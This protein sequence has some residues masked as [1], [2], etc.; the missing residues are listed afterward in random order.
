MT[1]RASTFGGDLG[2]AL[3]DLPL[4]PLP[5]VVL[6]PGA[7][8]PLHIFEP[9]YRAMIR[10]VLATH[11]ALAVVNV[12]DPSK[13]DERGMPVLATVAGVG[14]ILDHVE[15]PSGRFNILVRGR[16]RVALEERPFVPPYRRALATVLATTDE[17]VP[18]ESLAALMAASSAFVTLMRRR[19]ATF[20]LRAPKD[21][22]AGGFADHCAQQLLIDPRDRQAV[23]EATSVRER[24]RLVTETLSLQRMTLT[25]GHGAMN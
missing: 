3:S 15:L 14:T 20:E 21:A 2:S 24:V 10:D 23:L 5:E 17:D 13:L 16:A 25:A 6:L 18:S 8:M 7:L 9:R 22:D 4:F 12:P 1:S 19:D 11:G